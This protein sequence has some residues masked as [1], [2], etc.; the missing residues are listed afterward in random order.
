MTRVL[1]VVGCGRHRFPALP[2]VPLQH[3]LTPQAALSSPASNAKATRR[4]K[5]QTD[6]KEAM[7]QLELVLELKNCL[8]KNRIRQKNVAEALGVR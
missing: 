8:R 2:V 4:P 5:R 7:P 3:G 1:F 6:P